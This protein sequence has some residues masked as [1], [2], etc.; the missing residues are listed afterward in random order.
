MSL[1]PRHPSLHCADT[2]HCELSTATLLTEFRGTCLPLALCLSSEISLKIMKSSYCPHQFLA[3]TAGFF[4]RTEVTL[5]T[6][7]LNAQMRSL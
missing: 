1:Y 5:G 4:L 7:A 2:P 3:V 6:S